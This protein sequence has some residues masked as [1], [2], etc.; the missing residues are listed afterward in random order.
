MSLFLRYVPLFALLLIRNAIFVLCVGSVAL[1]TVPHFQMLPSGAFLH[2]V[3]VI[4]ST[5]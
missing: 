3:I 1:V 2:G 4:R 5:F